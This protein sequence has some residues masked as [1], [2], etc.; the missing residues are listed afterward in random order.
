[1]FS[2]RTLRRVAVAAALAAGAA[3]LT[4]PALAANTSEA[5]VSAVQ[6]G[7]RSYFVITA[8]GATDGPKAAVQSN[9]GTVYASYDAIGVIVA[10]SSSTGFAAAMRGVTGVQ[11]VG[12]TRT[13]DVPAAAANPAIPG[14]PSQITP[15]ANETNRAD[16]V[17]IGAD[18]AWAVNTGSPE[19]RVAV[20]DTGVDDQHYDLKANFD[21]TRSASCAYGKADTRAGAWRPVG[22]HGT[23]VAG[24]IAAAKNGKGI[25]GVAPGVKISSIRI[26]E[27]S[28]QLFFP[29]NTV[30]AFVFA[31]DQG[32]D[33]T[34]NS[35]YTDP[36]LFNCPSNV[37]QAAILEAVKRSVAY[38]EGKGVLNIAAA[39][40]ENYNLAS[41]TTD[42]TS[43]NDST[44]TNRTITNDCLNLPGELPGVV[45]VSSVG[46][47]NTKSSFSNYGTDKIH[48]AAPGESTYS[49]VPGGR[50]SSMSGTSMASPHV[51]GVAA[52]LASVNPT[53]TPAQ[54][55]AAL[56]AQ[57]DDL[58]CSGGCT[59][60]AAKNSYFGEGLV[61]A[62]EA[63]GDASPAGPSV[64]SPGNRTGKVGTAVSLQVEAT[65]PGGQALT[66]SA[67]GLP[68]GLTIS[69]SGL[70]TGTPTA[71]GTSNVTVT[72]KN[73]DNRTG[74]ATF[75]WTITSDNPGGTVTLTK[76]ANQWNFR[77]WAIQGLQIQGSST[78]GGSL[79]Y[80]ATGLPA[81]LTI[82]A[83]GRITGTPTTAGTSTVTVTGKDAGGSTGSTSFTWTIYGF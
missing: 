30:C 64:T 22:E 37:D 73:A 53:A 8:P 29:E 81:G 76:P 50:Y 65:D 7:L 35:Y 54:L 43:P 66:F 14:A 33:I 23:H 10:H 78:A 80:T 48:L 5:T 79:T 20:L 62:E 60:T 57:A 72:A 34:N 1:M 44:A 69:A 75:T 82:S 21:A 3:C 46:A 58:P 16:M 36:W 9:G 83:S 18:K 38:A 74:S 32:V 15:T 63:V 67:T 4:P 24:T 11:K 25:I 52:L 39:G 31:G 2:A 26:A 59:G 49:T 6:A 70:I 47:S 19:V 61:D 45:S 28:T 42:S 68:A 71:A 17:Q 56:A 77:G 27:P 13:S 12:A 40:N 55:R 41:K 51:A